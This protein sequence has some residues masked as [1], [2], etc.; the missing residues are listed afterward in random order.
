MDDVWHQRDWTSFV[1]FFIYGLVVSGKLQ[2]P[3]HAPQVMERDVF[4]IGSALSVLI[5]MWIQAALPRNAHY[6]QL[7]MAA[8]LRHT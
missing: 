5:Y 2:L 8:A 7:D 3:Q 4:L 6:K 1:L